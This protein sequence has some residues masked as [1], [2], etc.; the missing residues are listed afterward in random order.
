VESLLEELENDE[1]MGHPEIFYSEVMNDE[2]AGSRSSID[3]REINVWQER[4]PRGEILQPEGGWVIIDPALAKKTSDDCAIGVFYL[5]NGEPVLWHLETGKFNEMQKVRMCLE[6]AIRFKVM[7]VV[8]EAVAYQ[9]SLCYWIDHFRQ[10]LGLEGLRILTISPAG[11]AKNSRIL[12]MMKHLTAKQ[13]RLWVVPTVRSLVVHQLI[14]WNPLRQSNKD[15]ILDILAYAYL[16][17]AEYGMDLLLP[18]EFL[19]DAPTSSFS[20]GQDAALQLA[21]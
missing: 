15:D 6:L 3:F 12:S 20:Q 21:F 16:V 14:Y 4:G 2:E 1:S 11:I 10:Q 5:F 8:V 13:A 19:D 17:L 7:S 9:E 18:F